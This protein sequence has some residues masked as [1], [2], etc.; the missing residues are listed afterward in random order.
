MPSWCDGA[1]EQAEGDLHALL[2]AALPFAE[3]TLTKPFSIRCR[4]LVT[5]SAGAAR[6]GGAQKD[7]IRRPCCRRLYDGARRSCGT[8]SAFAFVAHV[9]V[10]GMKEILHSTPA[11]CQ[12]RIR[13]PGAPARQPVGLTPNGATSTDLV[14]GAGKYPRP[15]RCRMNSWL[16]CSVYSGTMNPSALE[17]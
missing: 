9:R 15:I 16:A 4:S 8:R 14:S 6:S 7:S 13:A 3:Q 2:N 1:S 10:G 17:I 12:A 5:W 11:S